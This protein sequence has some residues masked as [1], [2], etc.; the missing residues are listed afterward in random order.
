MIGISSGILA[1]PFIL[2]IIA[3]FLLRRNKYK[4]KTYDMIFID[5]VF[6]VY[7]YVT[8][9]LLYFPLEIHYTSINNTSIKMNF[10]PLFN[11]IEEIGRAS[12]RETVYI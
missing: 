11:T 4:N 10:V 5:I 1:V 6:F 12:C 7:C 9:G 3:Y 8:I 2:T